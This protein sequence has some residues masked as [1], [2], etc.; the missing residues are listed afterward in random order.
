M[1][2]GPAAPV[3]LAVVAFSVLTNPVIVY[4]SGGSG[5]PLVLRLVPGG[6]GEVGL[7]DCEVAA[8]A[9]ECVG[10]IAREARP[11][12][13]GGG[14]GVEARQTRSAQ[15]GHATGVGR[16]RTGASSGCLRR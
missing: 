1:C 13:G 12:G 6:D 14:S 11:D 5:I 10:R 15:R 3:S 7:A 8:T 16:G 2:S 4:V 9:A